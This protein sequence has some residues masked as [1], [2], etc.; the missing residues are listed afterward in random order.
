MIIGL[1]CL[2]LAEGQTCPTDTGGT[3]FWS[4]ICD[5]SRNAVCLNGKCTCTNGACATDGVC[6]NTSLPPT[7]APTTKAPTAPTAAPTTAAPTFP[8]RQCSDLPV[9]GQDWYST[10]FSTGCSGM[11]PNI[12]YVN[13]L[14]VQLP[15]LFV[16]GL[17]PTQEGGVF[18]ESGGYIPPEVIQSL[19]QIVSMLL[20]TGN[21]CNTTNWGLQTGFTKWGLTSAT[22][23]PLAAFRTQ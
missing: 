8:D 21:K 9:G 14:L 6:S 12:T 11:V 4:P 23:V 10:L 7:E 5:S 22:T 18:R 1:G 16:E 17:G 20:E 19:Y 13:S 3:C 15:S 2:P